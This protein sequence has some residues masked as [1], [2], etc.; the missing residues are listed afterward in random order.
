MKARLENALILVRPDLTHDFLL[1]VDWSS[2]GVG[3]VLSQETRGMEH[4]VAYA[5]KARTAIQRK[6]HPMEGE[7]Y[8]LVW[9][10]M[11]FS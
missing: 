11:H 6:Y 1:D 10:L 5:S 4:L 9:A 8:A 7:C 2:K 3:A